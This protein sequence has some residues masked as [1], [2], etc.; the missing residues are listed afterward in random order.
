M[1]CGIDEA[2]RG[3]LAGPLVVAGVLLD[4]EHLRAHGLAARYVS[5]YLATEPPP[6]SRTW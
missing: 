5:G 6:D 2:G 1:I 3:P 4:L